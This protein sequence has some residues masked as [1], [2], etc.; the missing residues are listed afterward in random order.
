MLRAT[1]LTVIFSCSLGVE[2]LAQ[3]VQLPTFRFFGVTTTVVVPDQGSAVLGG[4]STEYSGSQSRG[5]PLLGGVP[6]AGPLG[7][8]RGISQGGTTGQM[9]VT[10]QIH[11]LEAMDTAV[12]ECQSINFVSR[13]LVLNRGHLVQ[14][15]KDLPVAQR[16]LLLS[17]KQGS[18]TRARAL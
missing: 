16:C 11:D 12:L 4:N 13:L 2:L 7:Q 18:T 15:S 9:R 3:T 10:T 6:F 17:N 14:K 5:T 1:I 8:N